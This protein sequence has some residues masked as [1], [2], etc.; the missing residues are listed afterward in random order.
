M[1]R[2]FPKFGYNPATGEW[3]D[4]LRGDYCWSGVNF[5][6]AA[7]DVMTP[8]TWSLLW[9]Y[10]NI[11]FPIKIPGDHPVGGNIAGRLYFNLSVISS[12]YHKIGLDARNEKFGDLIGSVPA[13]MD[14]PYLPFSLLSMIWYVLPGLVKDQALTLRDRK[15]F[16]G[17][18]I[19]LPESCQAMRSRIEHCADA[20]GLL[21]LWHESIWPARLR[22]FR[23]LRSM[24]SV[25]SEPAT[26][27]K[28][29]LTSLVGE[30][31][32]NTLLSSL[33]GE[34]GDLESLGPLIGL[35]KVKDGRMSREEYTDWSPP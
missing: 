7:P 27:L 33:S 23:M 32:A 4:S 9:T 28:L 8:S 30:K 13:D 35:A 2:T 24:T 31:E 19:H 12:L 15:Q 1:E 29:D 34:S 17:Y 5:R 20:A 21:D 6:E 11:T 14:I 16:P 3:N 18:I 26:K 25:L 10:L 22:N